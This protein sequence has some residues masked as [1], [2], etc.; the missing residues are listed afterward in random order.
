MDTRAEIK[1]FLTTRRGRIRPEQV[2]LP[3]GANRRVPGLRRSEVATLA[4]LSVEYYSR[5]ERGDLAGVSDSVLSALART[6]ELDEAEHDHLLDLA[7]AATPT[8]RARR[9]APRHPTAV[10]PALQSMLDAITGAAAFVCNPA[11]DMIATNHLARALYS[12][13]YLA[14]ERPVNHSRFIFLDPRSQTTYPDWQRAADTNVAILRTESGRF[15]RDRDLAQVIGE[16]SMRSDEF[17]SRWSAH[18]VRRHVSGVKTFHHRAIG[19]IELGFEAMPLPGDV[20]LTLTVY[21]PAPHST[22]EESM[23]LLGSWTQQDDSV[24]R[25]GDDPGFDGSRGARIDGGSEVRPTLRSPG[26]SH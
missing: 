5:I 15:P 9:P 23:R 18:Q 25:R 14:A 20:G 2:G 13:M 12:D 7:H 26:R 11:Q 24:P 3:A 10:R 6:L 17:R 22:A 16:L 1:D 19:D 4:G 8:A 21:T